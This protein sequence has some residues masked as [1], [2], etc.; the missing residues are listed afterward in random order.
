ML[1]K[2]SCLLQKLIKENESKPEESIT[3]RVHLRRGYVAKIKREEKNISNKLFKEYFTIYR[4]PS[5]MHKKLGE[6]EGKKNEDQVYLIKEVLNRMKEAIKNVSEN[7]RFKIEENKK[8][9][10]II[11]RIL[12][13]NQLLKILKLNQMLSRLL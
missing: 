4:S 6:T 5:D 13:I 1:K 8:I 7:K 12:Y 10:N 9:I 2:I 3:K 11:E